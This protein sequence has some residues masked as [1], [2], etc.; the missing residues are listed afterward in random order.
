MKT[1]I[2][3]ICVLFAAAWT[4]G[5]FLTAALTEWLAGAIASGAAAD[6]GAALAGWQLPRWLAP[7]VDAQAWREAQLWLADAL[8][9]L[10]D[11]W[12]GFVDVAGW[13][14]AAIWVVWG[15]GIALLLAFAGLGHWLAGRGR[16]PRTQLA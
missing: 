9:W 16:A 1:A 3:S 8:A 6:F 4:G 13:L 12:P 15:F 11:V 5:A 14:V 7:W 10:R 2:W